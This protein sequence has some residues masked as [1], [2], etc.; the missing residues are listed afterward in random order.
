MEIDTNNYEKGIGRISLNED[1]A[2]LI[3]CPHKKCNTQGEY[4][5]CYFDDMFKQCLTFVGS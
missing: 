5:K 1:Y 2:T 3:Q 4:Y